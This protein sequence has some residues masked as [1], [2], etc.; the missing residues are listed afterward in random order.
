[1]RWLDVNYGLPGLLQERGPLSY[2]LLV[3]GGNGVPAGLD[4]QWDVLLQQVTPPGASS[5]SH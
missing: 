1:M 4:Q 3:C 2:P 5:A